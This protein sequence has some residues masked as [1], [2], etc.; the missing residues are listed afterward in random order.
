MREYNPAARLL[1]I[2]PA[3]GV[4]NGQPL[5]QWNHPKI[6]RFCPHCR[7]A[8]ETD[9]WR[10]GMVRFLRSRPSDPIVLATVEA[11]AAAAR[12]PVLVIEDSN[13]LT[14]VVGE[15]LRL[16]ARFVSPGS[17]FIVQDTRLTMPLA[18]MSAF[19]KRDPLG[20][21]FE[22]DRRLEYFIVGQHWHGYL[23]RKETG[24]GGC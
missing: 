17:Y 6:A 1:T 11:L 19:F 3:E 22:V 2:D 12:G 20:G 18:A 13:H 23:R 9:A 8:T 16:Y 24:E 14:E 7:H 4:T 15:N 21:C 5:K 10:S